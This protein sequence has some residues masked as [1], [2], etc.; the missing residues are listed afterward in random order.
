MYNSILWN[1][2]TQRLVLDAIAIRSKLHLSRY[3]R[4]ARAFVPDMIH[5]HNTSGNP[6]SKF[7][8]AFGEHTERW[9]PFS[10]SAIAVALVSDFI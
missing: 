4:Y 2:F 3:A 5:E 9:N 10:S 1:S 7:T 6:S 8:R